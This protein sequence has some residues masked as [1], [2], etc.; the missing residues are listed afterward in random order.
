VVAEKF[1]V[2]SRLAEGHPAVD[3][4]QNYVWACHALGYQNADLTLHGS[5]VRDSYGSE[6]GLDLRALDADCAALEA[7]L[8][9]TDDALARQDDQL[10][11]MT[12]AWQ[13]R[14]ADA[15][16]EF[17][18]RHAEA[19]AA[20]AAA[21][22]TAADALAALRDSL[23][24]TV[25]GKVTAAMAIDDR[26]QAQR[27]DWL[28]AAKTV[29]TGAGDRA[30]ASELIDQA[31]KPFVD[32]DIRADWLA[33]MRAAMAAVAD[34][35]DGAVAEVSS[36][37]DAVFEVPGDL[38][39]SWA[40]PARDDVVTT[41][42]G[43]ASVPAPV[44][45]TQPVWSASP[46]ATPMPAPTALPP[47]PPPPPS[48]PPAPSI[49]PGATAPA[50]AAPPMPSLGGT[51]GGMPDIGSGLSG[52]GQQ[53]A[54]LFGGLSGSTDALPDPPEID[55]SELDEPADADEEPDD[56]PDDEPDA[57]EPAT[58][59]VGE[60]ASDTV[61]ACDQQPAD[62]APPVEPPAEPAPT[63]VAVPP[64]VDPAPPPEPPPIPAGE[65]ET[66]CEIAA[67]DLPQVGP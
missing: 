36:E 1:D 52:F 39:P 16:R 6:D 59:E 7:T 51:G 3:N 15:S 30:V 50:M 8:A 42:A 64:P 61:D 4:I 47:P 5:Q 37:A 44:A 48:L 43:V 28:S 19:S 66:P 62:P 34:A 49:D 55:Q 67:D 35:Y 45:G 54:D 29:T 63:P 58:D 31:V 25:D 21:V 17:L 60:R 46:A 26:S 65:A 33:A 57:E 10:A 2:A 11:A 23:W 22:R 12:A 14:G 32:N 53:L 9:A 18:R 13:G 38:G 24:H 41:P 56:E 20:A 27:A 40:P